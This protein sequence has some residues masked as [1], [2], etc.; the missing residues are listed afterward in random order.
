MVSLGVSNARFLATHVWF[1]SC[2]DSVSPGLSNAFFWAIRVGFLSVYLLQ[3]SS[4]LVHAVSAWLCS[5]LHSDSIGLSNVAFVLASLSHYVDLSRWYLQS[6]CKKKKWFQLSS[7]QL[8][9]QTYSTILQS[10]TDKAMKSWSMLEWLWNFSLA[11]NTVDFRLVV[12]SQVQN[13]CKVTQLIR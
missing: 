6:I 8:G 11:T 2:L 7:Q 3:L 13:A 10:I 12:Q 1:C 4:A 5:F 9:M